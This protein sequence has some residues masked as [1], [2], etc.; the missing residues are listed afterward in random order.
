MNIKL[1]DLDQ[2]DYLCNFVIFMY[3]ASELEQFNEF[4]PSK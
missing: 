2:L 3:I 1:F 4:S